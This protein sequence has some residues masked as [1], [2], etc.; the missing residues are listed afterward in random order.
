MRKLA[1]KLSATS[2]CLILINT[3]KVI[4]NFEGCFDSQRRE[5]FIKEVAQQRQEGE[6]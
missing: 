1:I 3:N 6:E 5:G 2:Y 4:I